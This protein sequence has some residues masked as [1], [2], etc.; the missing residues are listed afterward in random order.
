MPCTVKLNLKARGLAEKIAE[1]AK[2]N[3]LKRH[4]FVGV[5]SNEGIRPYG[6][7]ETNVATVSQYLEYGWVQTVTRKQSGWFLGKHGLGVQPGSVLFM[8]PRPFLRSTLRHR[9]KEWSDVL[10]NAYLRHNGDI[11]KALSEVGMIATADIQ[12]TIAD[13]GIDGEQ[14]PRRSPL[15]Q[16]IYEIY[17]EG[18]KTDGTGN[19]SGDKPLVRSGLLLSSISYQ[20]DNK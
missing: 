18:H 5:N 4:V 3:A 2:A 14:F 10:K 17:Q 7:G 20:L 11:E 1:Q 6:E 9:A 15:T 12:Q 8:P 13:A 16:K 19:L